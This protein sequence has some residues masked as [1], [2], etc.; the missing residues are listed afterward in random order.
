M[1]QCITR[2]DDDELSF[3]HSFI[4]SLYLFI[5]CTSYDSNHVNI[6]FKKGKQT[7]SLAQDNNLD[8]S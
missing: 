5:E 4:H 3:I 8:D 6:I 1:M 7:L 2:I